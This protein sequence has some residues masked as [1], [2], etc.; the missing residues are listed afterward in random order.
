MTETVLETST[1]PE[2]IF[3]LIHTEKVEVRE[4]NGEI[5]LI[6]ITDI[7]KAFPLRGMFS[8]GKIS[9]D[10]FIESKQIEKELER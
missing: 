9:V 10:K 2:P 6:P 5:R 8:D 1:L 4:F 3:R 7:Q